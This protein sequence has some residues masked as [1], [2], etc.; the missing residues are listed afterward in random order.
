MHS[1]LVICERCNVQ[2]Y[3]NGKAACY[4]FSSQAVEDETRLGW[5]VWAVNCEYC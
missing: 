2:Q 5:Y 1:R 4:A 3:S